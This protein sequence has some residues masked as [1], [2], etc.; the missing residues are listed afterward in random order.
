MSTEL[1]TLYQELILD[2]NRHPRNFRVID[3]PSAQAQGFNPICGDK[4]FN[5]I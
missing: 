5:R 1:S 2:H 3:N 4:Y